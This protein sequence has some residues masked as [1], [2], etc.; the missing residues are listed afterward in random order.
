MNNRTEALT[1]DAVLRAAA[2]ILDS[3]PELWGR[4]FWLDPAT[5]CRCTGGLIALAVCPDDPDGDPYL[6]GEG[7]D[8]PRR[9]LAA[10][11]IALFEAYVTDELFDRFD[12]EGVQ[13]AG[14]PLIG[15]WNDRC[16]RD[17]AHVAA[18]MRAAADSAVVPA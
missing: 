10:E 12:P 13:A 1:P 8:D 18:T 6:V 4:E 17:A 5:G 9:A 14:E 2:L 11:A 7:R 3:H 16:A 15:L